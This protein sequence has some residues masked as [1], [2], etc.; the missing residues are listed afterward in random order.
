MLLGFLAFAIA[1]VTGAWRRLPRPYAVYM[2]AALALPL[3]FPVEPQ[4]LMSL[5]R[6]LAVLFPIFM[7][8][9]LWCEERRNTEYVIA[10]F[11]MGL[12]LFTAQFAS[13]H[14]IA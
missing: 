6:F 8:L 9:A 4:P 7:W 1:A 11:A 14:F 5:P 13:W 10:L 12:G 3:T 2:V